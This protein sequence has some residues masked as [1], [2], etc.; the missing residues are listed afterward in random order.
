M[1]VDAHCHAYDLPEHELERYRSYAIIA[2]SEDYES[3]LKTIELS[4]E[5]ENITPFIGIHPWNVAEA[6]RSELD[7]VL[8]LADRDE[9]KGLDKRVGKLYERQKEFFKEFCRIAS[10]YDLPLSIHA[11]GSWEDVLTL[12]R[13]YDIEKAAF[14]WYSGPPELL[15]QIE[16]NGYMITINPAVKV[17]RKHRAVLDAA[18]LDLIMTESDGPYKY[19]GMELKPDMIP[20]LVKFIAEVKGVSPESVEET[21]E[22]NYRRFLR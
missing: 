20:D 17:Q 19:R 2:V 5:Y 14:H 15:E 4:L 1:Y 11:L 9:V 8:A 3:S 10:E 13:R 12:L 6:S 22:W 18:S 16:E 21:V 7:K